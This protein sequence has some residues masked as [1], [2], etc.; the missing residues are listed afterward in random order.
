MRRAL[1]SLVDFMRLSEHGDGQRRRF[2]SDAMAK[3]EAE[4]ILLAV[5]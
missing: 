2:K 5:V 1:F 3:K 4:K